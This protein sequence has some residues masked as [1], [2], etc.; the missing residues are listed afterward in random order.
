MKRKNTWAILGIAT[1]AVAGLPVIA[2]DKDKNKDTSWQKT[3]RTAGEQGFG[4]IER[5]DKLIGREVRS[6]DNQKLGKIDDLV[7][8]LE[9]GHVLYAVLGSGGILGAGEKKHAVAPGAFTRGEGNNL[10]LNIDKDKLA[11]APEFTRDID[12][13]T[14]LPK[15]DFVYKVHQHYGQN[16]WWQG[17]KAPGEGTFN[18]VHKAS[19]LIGTKVESSAN[20]ELA[21]VENLGIDLP[22]GRVTYVILAPARQLELGNNLYA[23]PPDA[24]T[25]GTDKKNLVSGI[26]KEKLAAAPHFEKNNWDKLKDQSFASQVYQ[27]YGKQA[28]FE[29]GVQP[30][31]ERD[32]ARVYREKN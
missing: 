28:Y 10:R 21:K 14:E 27:Y 26:T 16:A 22:A 25:L 12:K 29:S 17:S 9:S 2:A 6:S 18:N 15:A 20:E 8:D 32:K 19:S 1:L 11:A 3:T 23:L 24:L 31:S 5:A 13:D 7:V 4:Q 30:T